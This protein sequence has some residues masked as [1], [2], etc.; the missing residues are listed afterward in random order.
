MTAILVGLLLC[1]GAAV[2][3][4]AAVAVPRV[5][6]GARLLTAGGQS[7]VREAH[8]RARAMAADER[9]ARGLSWGD[10]EPGPRHRR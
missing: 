4:L 5:R 3:V 1:T 6:E 10:P 8:L 2:A 7:A 9:L